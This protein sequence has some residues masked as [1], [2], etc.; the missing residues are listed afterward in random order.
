MLQA[1]KLSIEIEL[2]CCQKIISNYLLIKANKEENSSSESAGLEPAR[3][4]PN[5]FL[6]HR[7]NHSATTTTV[8]C[9]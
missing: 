2:A 3:G 1:F 7:L 4:D 8:T 6:V 5:G 9:F